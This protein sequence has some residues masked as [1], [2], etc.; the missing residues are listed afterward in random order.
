MVYNT[1]AQGAKNQPKRNG[2]GMRLAQEVV[3]RQIRAATGNRQV[4]N[5]TTNRRGGQRNRRNQKR[6]QQQKKTPEMLNKDLEQYFQNVYLLSSDLILRTQLLQSR[7]WT[8]S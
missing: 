2:N 8:I 1:K 7:I 6:A 4:A 3:S 5:K